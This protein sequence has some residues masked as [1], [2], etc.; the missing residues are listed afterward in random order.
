[1]FVSP[2]IIKVNLL[3]LLSFFHSHLH[4]CAL[5]LLLFQL[6]LILNIDSLQELSKHLSCYFH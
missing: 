2:I 4:T 6:L 5:R 1:M 3:I